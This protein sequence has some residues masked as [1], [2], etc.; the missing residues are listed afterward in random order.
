MVEKDEQPEHQDSDIDTWKLF[1][2]AILFSEKRPVF[3]FL[4]AAVT[5]AAAIG[6]FALLI[7]DF[8]EQR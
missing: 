6:V 8:F 3:T 5:Y 7:L 4:K 1:L 2:D